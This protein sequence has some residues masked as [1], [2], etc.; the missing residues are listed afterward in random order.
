[1]SFDKL[2]LGR[3]I[4]NLLRVIRYKFFHMTNQTPK[5]DLLDEK[6]QRSSPNLI[7]CT[8]R[9]KRPLLMM[10]AWQISFGS[11][12]PL[13]ALR[14]LP[15]WVRISLTPPPQL[16][17]SWME[18]PDI[19]ASFKWFW[20]PSTLNTTSVSVYAPLCSRSDDNVYKFGFMSRASSLVLFSLPSCLQTPRCANSP[21]VTLL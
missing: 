3:V 4:Q 7:D 20:I 17:M 21:T 8:K 16:W 9:E 1:M 5:L 11:Q 14:N 19:T 6:G 18:A 10:S 2:H 12:H 15:F 13:S